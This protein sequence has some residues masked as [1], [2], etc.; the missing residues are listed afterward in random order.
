MSEVNYEEEASKDGWVPQEEWK[1]APEKWVDA[2]TFVENGQKINGIL[3]SKVERL[4]S[5][6]EEN[7]RAAKEFKEWTDKQREKERTELKSRIAEL[8]KER[9]KAVSEGDGQKFTE[10]D[11]EIR[12]LEKA[13]QDDPLKEIA[14][15]WQ[16][17][18]TWYK[19]RSDDELSIYA[20]GIADRVAAEGY[21]GRAYFNEIT[22][23]V[24]SRF[25]E[26]FDNPR[27]SAPASVE[28]PGASRDR[29]SNGRSFN[30]L[31]PDAKAQCSRFLKEIPGFTK[32]AFLEQYDWD[33]E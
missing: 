10:V 18:N 11:R 4:E 30:D 24:Q 2:Q 22:R 26:K 28:A 14:A 13:P 29:P 7:K 15:A 8:E 25:P 31:P 33:E 19:P 32:E 21:T 16:T 12:K 27:R 6:L 1:G 3:K 9:E 20:D 5:A 23:R 17:E